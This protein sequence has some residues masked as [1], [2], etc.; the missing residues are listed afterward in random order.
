MKNE[1]KRRRRKRKGAGWRRK[2][3]WGIQEEEEGKASKSFYDQNKNYTRMKF[4]KNKQNVKRSSFFLNHEVGNR[5]QHL[6][7]LI[8]MVMSHN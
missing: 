8:F 1:K 3:R 2:G 6:N 7:H 4:S 5:I